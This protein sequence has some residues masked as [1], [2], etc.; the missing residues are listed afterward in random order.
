MAVGH[1]YS[2]D[3]RGHPLVALTHNLLMIYETRL[4]EEHGVSNEAE[5][6]RRQ[7]RVEQLNRSVR[8][9]GRELSSLRLGVRRATQRSVKF[10]RWLRQA[11]REN[12][13]EGDA[14]PR[15]TSL[16]ATL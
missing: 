5:D 1:F 11:L 4:E 2:L 3:L 15:L 6:E 13:A 7:Q 14:V 9:A 10:V 8:Q 16:Y 12:L